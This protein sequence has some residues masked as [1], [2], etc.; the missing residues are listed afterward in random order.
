[1]ARAFSLAALLVVAG[2]CLPV[3]PPHPNALA[4][5]LICSQY[6]EQGNLDKAQTYCDLALEFSPLYADALVNRGLIEQKRGQNDRARDWYIKALRN[7]NEQAQ[8]YNNLGVI[9][10]SEGQLGKAHDNFQRALK[11]DPNYIA[12]RYNLAV[13]LL[14]LKRTELAKK[15]CK[16]LIAVN[17]NLADPHF[18][19]GQIAYT[20]G[21]RDEAIEHLGRA[22]E[23]SPSYGEAQEL[24]GDALMDAGRFAEA[25]DAYGQCIQVDAD[26]AE[27]RKK[28]PLA[29][30]RA[31]LAD[32]GLRNL[33][34]TRTA[35]NTPASLFELARTYAEKGL[36]DKE[37]ATLLRCSRLDS[38]YP[39]CHFGLFQFYNEE[40]RIQEAV[41]ACRNFSKFATTQEYPRESQ[42]CEKF[43]S[44]T[45][46]AR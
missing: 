11:V 38:S 5:N 28:L 12:A 1:M 4:N 41:I 14:K 46:A 24:F 29:V 9:Y 39:P 19:L 35:D 23:L 45:S 27:C 33:E 10:Q 36:K 26:N 21:K 40:G 18:L 15:E 34:T 6:M 22:T 31:A 44:A 7:N 8:A 30:R 3:P 13:T 37:E 25:K 2:A 32:T 43:L 42:L 20:E 17:P 16:T